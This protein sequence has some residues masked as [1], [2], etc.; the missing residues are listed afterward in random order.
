VPKLTLNADKDVIAK[1]KE[2]ADER[3]ISVST[4][5]RQFVEMLGS[6]RPKRRRTAPITRRLRGVAKVSPDK[7]DRELYEEAVL[8]KGRR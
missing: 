3:G 1:A 6:R 4:M 5:F 2:I 7:S 8:A